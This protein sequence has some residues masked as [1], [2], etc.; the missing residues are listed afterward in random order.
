MPAGFRFRRQHG[1]D[2]VPRSLRGDVDKGKGNEK[3][4]ITYSVM[5]KNNR[6]C[7]FGCLCCRLNNKTRQ[8][9]QLIQPCVVWVVCVVV[10]IIRHDNGNNWNNL[11][12]CFGCP[13]CRQNNKNDNGNNW[14]NLAV[15]SVVS[16]VVK[17]I[18][19]DH[20]NNWNNLLCCFGCPCCLCCR[21]N[22]KIRQREQ[23]VQPCVVS[24]VCVVV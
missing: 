4:L 23:L 21:Q 11:L 20:G 3:K 18:R 6:L 5:I 10:K 15:V 12:C 17:I 7:C 16:V 8:R 14:Y 9:K 1:E 19:H 13:G 24:V 22:N 2:A